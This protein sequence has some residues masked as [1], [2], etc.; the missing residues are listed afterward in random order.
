[1]DTKTGQMNKKKST[2]LCIF[3]LLLYLCLSHCGYDIHE[4]SF[5]GDIEKVRSLLNQDNSL[6]H[7]RDHYGRTPLHWASY[8]GHLK[9][10]AL[11]LKGGAKIDSLTA[12]GKGMTSLH[13]A[14]EQG[15]K[16]VVTLLIN[17]GAD[18]NKRAKGI[19]NLHYTALWFAARHDSNIELIKLLI[20]KGARIDDEKGGAFPIAIKHNCLKT[21]QFF[22]DKGADI[23]RRDAYSPIHIAAYH[24]HK[25]MVKLLI[26]AGANVNIKTH[27]R[28]V[29]LF[30]GT[31]AKL[32]F[33]TIYA[34]QPQTL[35][36]IA[37]IKNNIPLVKLLI[38]HG[39]NIH[40]RDYKGK[41]PLDYAI[42]QNNKELIELLSH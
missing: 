28:S 19:K 9:V 20:A 38:S 39:A 21:T 8:N 42:E 6:V 24:C 36:H 13:I 40:Y 30:K 35:L 33:P 41:L 11:I 34:N 12:D 10:A 18:P 1:M 16:E 26:S 27:P 7:K 15:H 37:T 3:G 23:H 4:A 5:D 32:F 31:L 29:Q 17:N 22:I 25:E 14:S 2:L